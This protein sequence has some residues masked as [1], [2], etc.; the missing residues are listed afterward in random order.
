MVYDPVTTPSLYWLEHWRVEAVFCWMP[1]W[2]HVVDGVHLVSAIG[3]D[4]VKAH[5]WVHNQHAEEA[6]DIAIA[7]QLGALQRILLGI[8]HEETMASPGY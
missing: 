1:E 6:G 5:I 3:I 7:I 8:R 2:Q 4:G